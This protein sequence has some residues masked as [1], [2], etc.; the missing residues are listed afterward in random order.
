MEVFGN[1]SGVNSLHPASYSYDIYI[2]PILMEDLD[3]NLTDATPKLQIGFASHPLKINWN[4]IYVP[5]GN[6]DI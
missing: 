2:D 6:M 4:H 1:Y 3:Y 5:M